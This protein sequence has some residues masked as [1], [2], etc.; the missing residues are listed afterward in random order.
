MFRSGT[1]YDGNRLIR[2]ESI[3]ILEVRKLASLNE[4]ALLPILFEEMFI[5]QILKIFT[6]IFLEC[7]QYHQ[8]LGSRDVEV[9]GLVMSESTRSHY[10]FTWV[11]VPKPCGNLPE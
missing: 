5:F 9:N 1:K 8:R 2:N 10:I 7:I 11:R 6:K 4:T 3:N